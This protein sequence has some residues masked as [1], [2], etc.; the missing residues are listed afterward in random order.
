VVATQT[1]SLDESGAPTAFAPYLV[2]ALDTVVPRAGSQRYSLATID[3][4]IVGRGARRSV[5]REGAR[6]RIDVVDGAMSGT[7]FRIA[8]RGRGWELEDAGSK[9]GTFVDGAQVATVALGPD[10]VI[11]AARTVFVFRDPGGS[12]DAGDLALPIQGGVLDTLDPELAARF[13]TIP[14]L[15]RADL[16]LLVLGETGTGKELLARAIHDGSERKGAF[17]AVNCGALP[18]TLI[19]SEL[20]GYR[21]GAFSGATEDR[22]GL[23]RAADRGTLFLDEI[24]E[25]SQSAQAALLRVLQEHEV[26]PVGS[27]T[28][29]RVDLRVVS[30]TCQPLPALVATDRFRRDLFARISGAT[31]TLPSLRERRVDL[32]GLITRLL[33]RHD[34]T[35]RPIARA[36]ARALFAHAWPNNIRELDQAIRA[37]IAV[38]DGEL[39]TAHFALAPLTPPSA[40][41][42]AVDEAVTVDRERLIELL[43]QHKGN[44]TRIATQL[45]TSR[46]QVRRLAARFGLVTDDYRS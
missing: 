6:L 37:A 20:F 25:L 1:L 18:A 9:N 3:E 26:V 31:I 16:A 29:V 46:S 14:K 5:Q 2:L 17:V 30:A 32:G 12:V 35:D 43:R 19:E 34:A 33:E 7:H 23:V 42:A 27:Q 15:A 39:G 10:A 41:P 44:V 22:P 38:S 36:A 11:D 40:P 8:K 4:V 21:R 45:G 28:P 24:G 13:A